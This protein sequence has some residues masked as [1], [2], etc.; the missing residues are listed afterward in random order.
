MFSSMVLKR[1]TEGFVDNDEVN[2][3]AILCLPN[4]TIIPDDRSGLK[5]QGRYEYREAEAYDDE[6]SFELIKGDD[7]Y[8]GGFYVNAAYVAAGLVAACQSPDFLRERKLSIIPDKSLNIPGVRFDLER[9]FN[10]I[11]ANMSIE[12]GGYSG[13]VKEEINENQFGFVFASEGGAKTRVMKARCLKKKEDDT[14][15]PLFMCTTETYIHRL[16]KYNY[17]NNIIL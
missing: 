7:N 17:I 13:N 3:Y 1:L 15:E 9:H 10:Q 16:F 8:L 6:E 11:E 5:T 4:F 14:F 2:G 12:V